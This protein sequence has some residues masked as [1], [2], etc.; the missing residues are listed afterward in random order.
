MEDALRLD[1]L[2]ARDMLAAYDHPLM[3]VV[4]SIGSPLRMGG[5]QPA[6]RPGPSYD[7]DRSQI[8]ESLG[9]SAG[10]CSELEQQGAFGVTGL[11]PAEP[12]EA[13]PA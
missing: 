11:L 3:G 13:S 10:E 1:E 5:Y 12:T 2:Q 8:L 9:Y 7:G 6:Y 4:R